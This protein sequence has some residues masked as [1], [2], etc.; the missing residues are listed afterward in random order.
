MLYCVLSSVFITVCALY[1]DALR[2]VHCVAIVEAGGGGAY[3]SAAAVHTV[4]TLRQIMLLDYTDVRSPVLVNKDT[5]LWA[6]GEKLL[7]AGAHFCLLRL[8]YVRVIIRRCI[9]LQFPS[10]VT[11]PQH[12][13]GPLPITLTVVFSG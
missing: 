11:N 4:N 1:R 13:R 7:T 9:L 8:D 12:D 5:R 6:L 3:P 2:S 10:H